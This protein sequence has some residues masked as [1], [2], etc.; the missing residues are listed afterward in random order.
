M[1]ATS[2]VW[3]AFAASLVAAYSYYSSAT[4][5]KR[6]VDLARKSF[7]AM[8]A[9]VL[10]ASALLMFYILR[11][12]FEYAYVWNY[13]SRSL[14]THLLVTTFWAGQEGSFMFWALC[15]TII[16]FALLNYTR[17]KRIEYETMAVFSLLQ[18]FLLLLLIAKSPFK[19]VWEE[20]PT[21]ISVGTMFLFL[22][23]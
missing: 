10:A 18:A 4:G 15:S 3:M 2:L 21:Q 13:S 23:R 7:M 8:T 19:Y 12:H 5:K 17:R 1:L 11:H 14:P 22:N 20:F 16:G 6:L 9:A